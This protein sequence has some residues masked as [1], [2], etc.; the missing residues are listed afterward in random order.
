MSI[1]ATTLPCTQTPI[2]QVVDLSLCNRRFLVQLFVASM[3]VLPSPSII[4]NQSHLP[5]ILFFVFLDLYML[6]RTA[7]HTCSY[8]TL[9]VTCLCKNNQLFQALVSYTWTN[10]LAVRPC[11]PAVTY[12]NIHE[13][14]KWN[15]SDCQYAFITQ[16]QPNM[17]WMSSIQDLCNVASVDREYSS[18][19][20]FTPSLPSKKQM[21]CNL[22]LRGFFISFLGE[23]SEKK[24]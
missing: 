13:R 6:N 24:K 11:L 14:S 10:H 16:N 17:Y 15:L 8:R 3:L 23:M 5:S 20:L 19:H 12:I 2:C 21:A 1:R 7:S 18:V 4:S 9:P 22:K